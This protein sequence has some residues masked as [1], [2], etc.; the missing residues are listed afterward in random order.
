M[1]LYVGR[2][3]AKSE[4]ELALE[5]VEGE[6]EVVS[7][8]LT[9]ELREVELV[10]VE[11][12]RERAERQPVRPAAREVLDLHALH[13]RPQNALVN[14]VPGE[15]T[16]LYSTVLCILCSHPCGVVRTG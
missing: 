11:V 6:R 14:E 1:E 3:N 5:R 9:L 2:T 12:V 7:A 8:V 10:R 15:R 16:L 13:T 4:R